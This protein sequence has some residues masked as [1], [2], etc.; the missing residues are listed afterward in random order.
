M[1]KAEL[2]RLKDAT[3]KLTRWESSGMVFGHLVVIQNKATIKKGSDRIYEFYCLLRI[4]DDLKPKYTIKLIPGTRAG[5]IFPQAPADKAGWPY[6][7]I[8]HIADPS[9]KFQVCYGTNI[10]LSKA[11][12]TTIAP[13]ISVQDI[14]STDDPDESMVLLIMDA[15]FKYNA[16]DALPIDQIHAFI[17]RVNALGTT[18][19]T[20]IP[21]DL[22]ALM[23]LKGNCLLTN[24]KALSD[25]HDYCV[26]S[27]V[28]QVGEF[29]IAKSGTIVG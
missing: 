19:A 24:G 27:K 26:L 20:T 23:N 11:P 6:F 9:N 15:K 5:K 16:N 4:L 13:D 1:T 17:Q 7:M 2:K 14:A 18:G 8:E 3:K 12:K 21:L 29:D 25:Q 28:K 22:D 10:K